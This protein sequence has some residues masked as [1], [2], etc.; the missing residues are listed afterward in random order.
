MNKHKLDQNEIKQIAHFITQ[1]SITTERGRYL[2][3]LNEYLE[4]Y[5]QI[6]NELE[7][8]NSSTN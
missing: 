1:R 5:N 3:S 6:M 4:I 2:V 8:Y 7:K